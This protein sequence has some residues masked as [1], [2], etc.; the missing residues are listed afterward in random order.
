MTDPHDNI[1]AK[2]PAVDAD[3]AAAYESTAFEVLG[4]R[5]IVLKVQDGPDEIDAAA[6]WL[7]GF[8]AESAIVITAWNPFS[9]SRTT[10]WNEAANERLQADVKA[11]G[12]RWLP[13]RGVSED[14]NWSEASGCV[15]DVPP[16]R[17]DAWLVEFRQH[18]VLL[19]RR[20]ESPVLIWHPD[21]RRA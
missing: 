18:A 21:H 14:G 15:F 1:S 4:D 10:E 11:A 13:A 3:L 9:E 12:R 19:A 2:A 8:G 7:A 17:V 20:G 5:P 6:T 16:Q